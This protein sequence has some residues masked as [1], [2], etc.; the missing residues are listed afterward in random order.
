MKKR[1]AGTIVLLVSIFG[2]G[3]AHA[4]DYDVILV[5]NKA[6]VVADTDNTQYTTSIQKLRV[7]HNDV[8]VG[9]CAGNP[10]NPIHL[11]VNEQT[12]V[13]CP[14]RETPT[15]PFKVVMKVLEQKIGEFPVYNLYSTV[16]VNNVM[17]FDRKDTLLDMSPKEEDSATFWK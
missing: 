16:W 14:N 15:S 2:L 5:F 4:D 10:Q 3:T 1:F 11:T 6:T 9:N 8:T 17:L 7:I 13:T 12:Y